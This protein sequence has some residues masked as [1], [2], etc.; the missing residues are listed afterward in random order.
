MTA[1]VGA[2]V[3]Q[4]LDEAS[5]S[6][7][8]VVLLKSGKPQSVGT[9]FY[10]MRPEEGG[11]VILFL[12][13]NHHV[14]TG[15]APGGSQAPD[16]DEIVFWCHK[17]IERPQDVV[18]HRI[19]IYNS[20]GRQLWVSNTAAPDADIAVLPLPGSLGS[21]C[22]IVALDPDTNS[23]APPPLLRPTSPVAL[24]GYPYG[25]FDQANHLPIWKTG[26]LASEPSTDFGGR[27]V[28]LADVSAF[29]GM[30]G[31]PV[32]AVTNGAYE[33][34]P[35]V[36]ATGRTRSF[37]GIFSAMRTL[38]ETKLV[39]TLQTA[40]QLVVKLEQSLELGYVWKE[41]LIREIVQGFDADKYQREV[42]SI[43]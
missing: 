32:Y 13:T 40:P 35:G 10:Y 29:P 7:T 20:K 22:K 16:G 9:G 18:E 21:G 23:G 25:F 42:L 12:V 33:V 43:K 27:P 15:H 26:A 30:S 11:K 31:S 41:R 1:A 14:L 36:V 17:T 8:R 2:Q 28:M 34:E 4:P 38:R 19:R 5:L 6:T 24:I 39:E 37:I 3:S